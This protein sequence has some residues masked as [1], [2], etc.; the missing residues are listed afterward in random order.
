MCKLGWNIDFLELRKRFRGSQAGCDLIIAHR[1]PVSLGIMPIDQTIQEL[2]PLHLRPPLSLLCDPRTSPRCLARVFK[3]RN[4]G[5]VTA[6]AGFPK[7]TSR[8]S[9]LSP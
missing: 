9:M 6:P 8:S 7:T 1:P 4:F 3:S 2:L 5:T